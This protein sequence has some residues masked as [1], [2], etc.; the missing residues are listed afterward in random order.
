[1]QHRERRIVNGPSTAR[2]AL[3]AEA[4]GDLARLLDRT[5]TIQKA[6][7][8]SREAFVNAHVQLAAQL[9]AFDV[10]VAAITEK[11]KVEAVKHIFLR[12]DEAARRM[13]AAQT[14]AMTESGQALF[15][16]EI[17]PAL[18]RLAVPLWHL[19]KR[20]DRR[21]ERWLAHA[22]TALTASA[23]SWT[24]ALLWLR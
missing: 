21:W 4:I 2:E 9:G 7:A 24:V 16:S 6:M 11:A 13:I 12:T 18:Q 5:E 14:Q 15:K 22:A 17:E 10:Q 1:V 20:M 3:I 8:E 19:A 23:L